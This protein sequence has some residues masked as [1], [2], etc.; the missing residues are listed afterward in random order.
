MK[1]LRNKSNDQRIDSEI[2]DEKSSYYR[3]E[4]L[5]ENI[6]GSVK[7]IVRLNNQIE[8]KK[9]VISTMEA[10][11]QKKKENRELAEEIEE[12]DRSTRDDKF[13]QQNEKMVELEMQLADANIESAK[14]HQI[15][16][17]QKHLDQMQLTNEAK[18]RAISTSILQGQNYEEAPVVEQVNNMIDSGSC[19]QD[20]VIVDKSTDSFDGEQLSRS[21]NPYNNNNFEEEEESN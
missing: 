1:E 20:S 18:G 8:D 13:R 15:T 7:D 6:A 21:P 2:L 4:D 5:N 11:K 19:T 14:L 17:E 12:F 16:S 10:I 9:G 3:K